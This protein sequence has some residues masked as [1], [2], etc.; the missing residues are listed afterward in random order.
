MRKGA[1][2]CAGLDPRGRIG[3]LVTFGLLVVGTAGDALATEWQ[4]IG[5]RYQGMGGTGVA[6]VDDSLAVYWNPGALAFSRGR[7]LQFSFGVSVSAEGDVMREIDALDLLAKNAKEIRDKVANGDPLTDSEKAT[8]MKLVAGDIPLFSEDDET[9]L[10]R[11]HAGFRG[12]YDRFGFGLIS[13]GDSTIA[14]FMDGLRLSLSGE[15]TAE[16]RIADITG[17]GM[18][19]SAEL[20][21]AGQSLADSIADEFRAF[22]ATGLEQNQAE[23]FV[24]I[25]ESAGLNTGNNRIRNGLRDSARATAGSGVD[26]VSD[27]VT[28]AA[29]LTLVTAE[30]NLAYGHP[31]FEKI[32]VGGGIRYIYANTFVDYTT[33]FDVD[34][35][36]ELIR[37]TL[38][39]N[40]RPSFAMLESSSSP[41]NSNGRCA[42][43][44]PTIPCPGGRSRSM[45]TSRRTTTGTPRASTPD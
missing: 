32:G 42:S 2:G 36:S 21:P 38:E 28:G 39:F 45:P 1:V 33:F 40:N 12:R 34:S 23:E 3:W 10:P 15:A 22:T 37:E 16:A 26:L 27:N 41:S 24:F 44:S 43:E 6:V 35:V 19:R 30:T 25:G 5:A 31:F 18:D 9:F 13:T 4:F 20:T 7:D 29:A 14:P 11:A 8:L 17:P